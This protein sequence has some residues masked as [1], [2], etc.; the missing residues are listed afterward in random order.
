MV[1]A[2]VITVPELHFE[3]LNG[4]IF[5]VFGIKEFFIKFKGSYFL[6]QVL[7]D[8]LNQSISV[9]TND[10]NLTPIVAGR[11]ITDLQ[12]GGLYPF[13]IRVRKVGGTERSL[14]IKTVFIPTNNSSSPGLDG[15][16]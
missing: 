16:A 13:E 11:I 3:L 4:F 5:G 7:V 9:F 8:D 2:I 14:Q 6:M 15:E 1:F 12:K 10:H